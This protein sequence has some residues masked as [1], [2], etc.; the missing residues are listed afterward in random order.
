MKS[1]EPAETA[2]PEEEWA[3]FELV[4]AFPSASGAEAVPRQSVA[5]DSLSNSLPYNDRTRVFLHQL[6]QTLTSLRGTLE[7]A[8]LAD[9]DAQEYRKV[10]QQ[11]LVQAENMVQLYQSYRASAE[12]EDDRPCE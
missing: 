8:L 5:S 1:V 3:P 4:R 2:R 11:S 10:I 9:S 12:G 6:S 7:L